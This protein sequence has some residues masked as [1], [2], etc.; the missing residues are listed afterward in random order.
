[1]PPW[2]KGLKCQEGKRKGVANCPKIV[3][4][5]LSGLALPVASM[6]HCAQ[7]RVCGECEEV[8]QIGTVL[9]CGI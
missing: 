4:N 1:V 7:G 3:N 5:A 2:G 8:A 9:N 6:S